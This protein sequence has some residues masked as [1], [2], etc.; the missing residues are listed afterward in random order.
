MT[1]SPV[2]T[3]PPRVAAS[4]IRN[5]N[6]DPHGARWRVQMRNRPTRSTDQHVHDRHSHRLRDIPRSKPDITGS[7]GATPLPLYPP[8]S[9]M[10]FRVGGRFHPPGGAPEDVARG[11]CMRSLTLDTQYRAPARREARLG[12]DTIKDLVLCATAGDAEAFGV[13][14]GHYVELVYRYAY[15]RVGSH[16]L[17]E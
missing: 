1:S 8:V 13:L 10:A 5:P 15:Y 14:Y 16:V 9:S 17:A 7:T 2:D 12:G 4:A 3:S 11:D 6:I